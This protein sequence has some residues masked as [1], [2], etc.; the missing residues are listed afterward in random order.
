MSVHILTAARLP[1][2]DIAAPVAP[3]GLWQESAWLL[4]A[5]PLVS[6]AILLLAGRRS[7]RWG[8]WFGVAAS[9]ASFFLV[10]NPGGRPVL[11]GG[12]PEQQARHQALA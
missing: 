4:V 6:A 2:A 1:F 9:A 7:D 3:S 12:T 11:R 5:I 10:Y 8:H